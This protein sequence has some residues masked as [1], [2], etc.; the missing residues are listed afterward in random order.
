MY[1]CIIMYVCMYVRTYVS[2]HVS[3]VIEV[4]DF[5]HLDRDFV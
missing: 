4:P 3:S 5:C 1:M 2:V